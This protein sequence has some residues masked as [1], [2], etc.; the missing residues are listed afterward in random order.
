MFTNSDFL[1]KMKERKLS[2]RMVDM[3]KV[4][5]K[6]DDLEEF[7]KLFTMSSFFLSQFD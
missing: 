6:K 3:T 5:G 7:L 4:K 1:Q 2:I